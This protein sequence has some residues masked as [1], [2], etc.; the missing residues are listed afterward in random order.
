MINAGPHA[1]P[2]HLHHH[3]PPVAQHGPVH[4]PERGRRDRFGLELVERPG[5]P[6]PQLGGH[7][8]LYLGKGTGLPRP[9]G[10]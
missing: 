2:L 10:G 7:Y 6:H 3:L 4:L 5:Y 9:A 1:G 8:R